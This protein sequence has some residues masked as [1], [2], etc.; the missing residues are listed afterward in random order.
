[1]YYNYHQQN[2]SK[3]VQEKRKKLIDGMAYFMKKGFSIE[4]LD[5]DKN[6]IHENLFLRDL[7]ANDNLMLGDKPIKTISVIGAQKSAKSTLLNRLAVEQWQII[8]FNLFC[9]FE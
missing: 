8:N 5:G 2:S 6:M 9:K 4:L 3:K 7:V 1:M